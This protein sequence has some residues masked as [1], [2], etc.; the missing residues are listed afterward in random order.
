MR[1]D[2]K[3]QLA[4]AVCFVFDARSQW[5]LGLTNNP[6]AEIWLSTYQGPGLQAFAATPG[7]YFVLGFGGGGW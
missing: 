6:S 1:P 4:S 3:T 7:F 5:G 2:V